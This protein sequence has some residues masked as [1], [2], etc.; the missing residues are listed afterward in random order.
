VKLCS[1]WRFGQR[2]AL[3]NVTL[4]S[5]WRFVQRDALFDVTLR[6][7]RRFAEATFRFDGWQQQTE[8]GSDSSVGFLYWRQGDQMSSWKIAQNV[9]QSIFCNNYCMALTVGKS[10]PKMCPLLWCPNNCPKLSITQWAKL[11]PIWSHWYSGDHAIGECRDVE[12]PL[13]NNS[14]RVDLFFRLIS[15][16]PATSSI[17]LQRNQSKKVNQILCSNVTKILARLNRSSIFHVC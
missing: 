14:R 10:R 1:T 6:L 13:E 5:T 3:S 17:F 2:D 11:R 7:T 16:G 15:I 8:G 9:A 4:C 12:R